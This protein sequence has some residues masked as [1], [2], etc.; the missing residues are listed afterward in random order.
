MLAKRLLVVI[1][2]VPVL[3]WLVALGDWPFTLLVLVALT[4]SA[5]EYAAIFEKGGYAPA[6]WVMLAGVIALTI[7][8]SQEGFSLA[9]LVLSLAV[10]A[11][12][13]VHVFAYERGQ[14]RSA[15][16]LA[17]TLSGIVYLGWLGGYLI[18]LRSLPDGAWW[19]LL[20][21][22]GVWFSDTGGYLFGMKWGKHLLAP[23]VSP[24]KTWEGYLGGIICAA[25]GTTL[26]AWLW[27]LRAP[28]IQPLDGLILGVVLAVVTPMGDL[29]ESLF[30]RQFGMKD[31]SNLI[32][33]H[34]GA[35]DRID[36][37][38]W[39]GVIGYY[40]VLWLGAG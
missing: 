16:D 14:Q 11:A 30:K 38:L 25:A 13:A 1:L 9:S 35:F 37:W 2:L 19:L 33:G 24:R 5:W 15:S 22:P 4:L 18:S 34:G 31:S 27:H 3:V 21:L 28:T 20:V 7:A 39:A 10:M 29:G 32:P 40:M 6:K 12:T 17:I 26:L 36:S 8:R 23:R